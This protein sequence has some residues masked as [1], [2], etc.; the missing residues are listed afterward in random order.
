VIVLATILLVLRLVAPHVFVIALRAMVAPIVSMTIV[1][2]LIV[3]VV[4]DASMVVKIFTTVMLM[5]AKFMA[6][7]NRKLSR[8]PFLWLLVL[9][10]LLKNASHLVGCLT[11]LKEG[12]HLEQAS[13]YCLV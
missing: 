3:V 1:E 12:N 8:F 11:L 13:R 5:V 10:N 2:S 7:F 6:T 4:S 9:G